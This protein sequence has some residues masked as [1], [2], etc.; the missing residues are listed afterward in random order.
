MS[1]RSPMAPIPTSDPEKPPILARRQG[2]HAFDI[3]DTICIHDDLPVVTAHEH[4]SNGTMPVTIMLHSQLLPVLELEN[5]PTRIGPPDVG[6]R[7]LQRLQSATPV[8]F[9]CQCRPKYN[10]RKHGHRSRLLTMDI[11]DHD[12]AGRQVGNQD[13]QPKQWTFTRSLSSDF[14]R[15]SAFLQFQ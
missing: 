1:A 14:S 12:N 8:G 4:I 7:I 2:N 9:A 3:V 10:M 11:Q 13:L 5:T 15:P 6:R